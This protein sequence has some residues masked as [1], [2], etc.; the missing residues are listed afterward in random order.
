M[1]Q[2]DGC[3]LT[4]PRGRRKECLDAENGQEKAPKYALGSGADDH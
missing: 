4:G 3:N 1:L 2:G